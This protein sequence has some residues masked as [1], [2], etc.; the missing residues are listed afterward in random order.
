[1]S[2]LACDCDER[3]HAAWCLTRCATPAGA[4]RAAL[5]AVAAYERG[6]GPVAGELAVLATRRAG[7]R[8]AAIAIREWLETRATMLEG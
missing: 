2:I 5:A 4:V 3:P 7:M 8:A 6:R 1:V